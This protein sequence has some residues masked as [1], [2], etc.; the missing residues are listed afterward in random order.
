MDILLDYEMCF[1]EFNVA[2]HVKI[3]SYDLT[4]ITIGNF[5]YGN[6]THF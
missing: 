4:S 5:K 6:W 1:V 3:L 2:F